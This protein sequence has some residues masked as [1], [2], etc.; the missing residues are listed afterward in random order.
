[1]TGCWLYELTSPLEPLAV[2]AGKVVDIPRS[3]S[4]A[5]SVAVVAGVEALGFDP[6]GGEQDIEFGRRAWANPSWACHAGI[7]QIAER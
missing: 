7:T 3:G 4:Q 2:T 1:M 5:A 6:L